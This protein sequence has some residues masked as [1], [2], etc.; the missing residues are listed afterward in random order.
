MFEIEAGPAPSRAILEPKHIGVASPVCAEIDD[1]IRETMDVHLAWPASQIPGN[2]DINEIV[3]LAH[4]LSEHSRL[5]AAQAIYLDTADRNSWTTIKMVLA[6]GS[7][8][9]TGGLV[10]IKDFLPK[11][12]PATYG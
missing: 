5:V 11:I 6:G 8:T 1:A 12:Q 2:M 4:A 3:H 10:H 7:A 9:I